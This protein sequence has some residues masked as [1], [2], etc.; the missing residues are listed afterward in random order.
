MAQTFFS[1]V[2]TL[3]AICLIPLAVYAENYD[4]WSDSTYDFSSVHY[5]LT[6]WTPL[7]CKQIRR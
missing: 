4:T 3:L 5:I 6:R 2:C 1:R 7:R